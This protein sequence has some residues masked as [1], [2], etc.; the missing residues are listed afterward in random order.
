VS[1][2]D[3]RPIPAR[4]TIVDRRGYLPPLL[5]D[6]GQRLAVRPGV[7]YTG[8]GR[9]RVSLP[10]GRY[11]VYANRG[12]EW[13]VAER[14]VTVATGGRAALALHIGR[15]V[16]TPGLVA[17]DTHVHTFTFSRHGDATDDERALTLAGEGIELPIATEHNQHSAHEEAA[18]RMGVRAFFTPV[19]GNEVTTSVGHFIAFPIA[20]GSAPADYTMR[21]W[22]PL[23]AAIRATPG[24]QVVILNHPRDLH[25]GFVPFAPANFDAATG[26]FKRPAPEVDALE[27]VNSGTMRSDA[28]DVYR[29]WFALLNAGQRVFG[30]GSSDSHDVNRSIVGQGRTYVACPDGDPGALDVARAAAA[31]RGGQLLV[32]LGLLANLGVDGRFGVGDL[33][34][35]LGP[36]MQV[37][38]TVLGPSWTRVD[39]IR[40]YGNGQVLR[41]EA[42]SDGGRPGEKLRRTWRLPRP[43]H[44]MHLVAVAT[45]PGVA[46]AYWPTPRPYQPTSKAWTPYVIGS[47][48]PIWIDGDGDGKYG[49]PPLARP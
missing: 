10:A 33:A 16:P 14:Q 30:V 36:E 49:P 23:V 12:F 42:V 41:D 43:A 21:E 38:A 11:T 32:S 44:D 22:P 29:D 20:P 27:L 8:D 1:D 31:F 2:P 19:L 3:G 35:G 5:A 4:V 34:T 40:L 47:T 18:R 48:N 6:P 13:G 25:S 28:L 7:V 26:Q 24:V 46:A 9:A 39:R 45:G 17:S 37:T 15:E